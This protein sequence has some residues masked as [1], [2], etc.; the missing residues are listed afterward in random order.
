[1]NNSLTDRTM[2]EFYNNL[3][4][5]PNKKVWQ[6]WGAYKIV[7]SQA[8]FDVKLGIQLVYNSETYRNGQLSFLTDTRQT[9]RIDMMHVHADG[10]Q[11]GTGTPPDNLPFGDGTPNANV[12]RPYITDNGQFGNNRLLSER[13]G[14]RATAFFTHDF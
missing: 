2:F 8:F 3:I 7:L 1:K 11:A 13:V 4:D 10:T 9:I 6:D 5:G 12:G 14:K